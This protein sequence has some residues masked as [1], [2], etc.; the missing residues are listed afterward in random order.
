MN[1]SKH[2]FDFFVTYRAYTLFAV[3]VFFIPLLYFS[4]NETFPLLIRL[5]VLIAF[6]TVGTICSKR[7]IQHSMR[8]PSWYIY[9]LAMIFFVLAV[10]IFAGIPL[11]FYRYTPLVFSCFAALPLFM[12][13]IQPNV[14]HPGDTD[15]A[16]EDE[17]APLFHIPL[18]KCIITT[19]ITTGVTIAFFIAARTGEHIITPWQVVHPFA[20]W[21]VLLL[22]AIVLVSIFSQA[23]WKMVL[24][25][26]I[27]HSCIVHLYLPIV[28]DG[29]F[30]GDRWRHI[31]SER[32][33][34]TGKIYEPGLIGDT[35][36]PMKKIAGIT[37]PEVFI[38]GNKTS[39]AP[40]WAL[41]IFTHAMTGV[42][43][44]DVDQ[45]LVP[46][47]WFWFVPMM[48]YA[49]GLML[50]TNKQ[51]ALLCAFIPSIFFPY[52][53]Y[54]SITIAVGIGQMIFLFILYSI[55]HFIRTHR[56]SSIIIAGGVTLLQYASYIIPLFVG[57][58]SMVLAGC[59]RWWKNTRHTVPIFVCIVVCLLFFIFL[60]PLSEHF[61]GLS[62]FQLEKFYPQTF[63][64]S[65]ADAFGRLTN[66]VGYNHY[67]SYIGEG[68]FLYEASRLPKSTVSLLRWPY[69]PVIFSVI[70]Y[71]IAIV[72][73]VA[74][75]RKKSSYE[76]KF[77]ALL[78]SVLAGSYFISWFLMD[79]YHTLARRLDLTLALL[80]GFLFLYG[81]QE[82]MSI[83]THRSKE[84]GI[85]TVRNM[86]IIFIA[87]MTF[88]T[89]STYASGPILDRVTRNELSAAQYVWE[90]TQTSSEK[91]SPCV[92][93]NTWPLLAVESVSGR[94]IIG[95]GFPVYTEYAQP[96]R[97][98]LFE[99][100]SQHPQK[101]LLDKALAVTEAQKCFYM[102]E[103]RFI[104][105][106]VYTETVQLLGVPE[107]IFGDV[108][109]WR[110]P[111]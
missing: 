95:G 2:V 58:I 26:I 97:V 98:K 40:Q 78:C 70:V 38:A 51:W 89:V 18:K 66:I 72:G 17:K 67:G 81:F 4:F 80:I 9:A 52:Q 49:L 50:F 69:W 107:K 94:E 44:E 45:W 76:W 84:G 61:F 111:Q 1:I 85:L 86:S 11:V 68:N 101:D 102:T 37:V 5:L 103:Y 60:I 10:S 63:I 109:I 57:I 15:R 47:L 77:I 22:T 104:N 92:L 25:M 62:K 46:L 32:Y 29:G 41:T 34:L 90:H 79:G 12:G 6:I 105:R 96:E 83:L 71:G 100:M 82:C 88:A 110:Y 93:G 23:S 20:L 31:A 42:S 13:M 59:V 55:M 99:K 106:R 33:L 74:A 7:M 53:V 24:F 35:T 87:G 21:A 73:W 3:Y 64:S 108:L 48:L 75:I 8:M 56:I 39:Y 65:L 16:S 19:L 54:G 36:V 28:Y 30:G 27:V 14:Y 91:F 43:L